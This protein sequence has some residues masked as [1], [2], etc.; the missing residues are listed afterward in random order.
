MPDYFTPYIERGW[1]C[2]P[3]PRGQKTPIIKW[4]QYQER[5][6]SDAEVAS[7]ENGPTN[8]AIVTGSVSN[9]IVVDVD[10]EAGL[11]ALHR[12]GFI[13]STPQV[14][15]AKGYHFYFLHPGGSIRNKARFLPDVDL[16]ADG[17]YVIAPPSIHES[18]HEYTWIVTPD[19]RQ[20]A[21]CPEWLLRLIKPP[22]RSASPPPPNGN[23]H[24]EP[25]GD[26]WLGKALAIAQPGTRDETGFWLACQLRDAGLSYPQQETVLRAYAAQCPA[27]DHPFSV[28]EALA[29]VRSANQRQPRG[30][31]STTRMASITMYPESVWHEPPDMGPSAD[32]GAR[33][34][35]NGR[36][37][38]TVARPKSYVNSHDVIS[39]VMDE[40]LGDA[41][42]TGRAPFLFPM[43]ALH[44]FGGFAHYAWR[45]KVTYICGG[46]GFGKTML[47]EG[48][49]AK[50]NQD[51]GD[52][53][54]YGP[55]WSPE[56]MIY[57]AIQRFGGM[58]LDDIAAYKLWYSQE[59][60][61]IP[62][63]HRDGKPLGQAVQ[64]KSLS[65][66]E[67]MLKWSGQTWF[68]PDSDLTVPHLVESCLDAVS[69][70][71]ARG[72]DMRAIVWD[73]LQLLE[74]FGSSRDTSWG[75]RLVGVFK[76]M[77]G[78]ADVLGILLV[79]PRKSDT[80]RVRQ[81]AMNGEPLMEV[82]LDAN[83]GHYL[84][85][86]KCNL[87]V[88]INPHYDVEGKP[89]GSGI[90]NVVKNSGGRTGQVAIKIDY[91]RLAFQD[92]IR[93]TALE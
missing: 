12:H 60:R 81:A 61:G 32:A 84:S 56:E 93:S 42:D 54:W 47:G 36:N 39:R 10:G 5:L 65:A 69:D 63:A 13:P 52:V 53:V 26:F 43:L 80:D 73:Y 1:S 83:S 45:R 28:K 92:A 62:L 20:I 34:R 57:R 72:R 41:S 66:L 86:R 50:L 21:V 11:A 49:A 82:L 78:V 85:D 31:A 67:D 19:E 88:T 3:V 15:T 33:S 48:L 70:A 90:L 9:L 22:E 27:G 24:R 4:K 46:P 8:V 35:A 58:T 18:G 71:R 30:P 40:V 6:P 87:Y 38:K 44:Q 64:S 55:E 51:G 17:G 77:C 74:H 16:R 25:E 59:K 68:V 76:S 23:G 7:W 89:T 2:I 37:E 75:E 79:Q 14:R 29:K 91:P